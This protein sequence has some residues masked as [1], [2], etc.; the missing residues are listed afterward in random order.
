MTQKPHLP[1]EDVWQ[2][3]CDCLKGED[4]NSIQNQLIR[5]VWFEA[6]Y[7]MVLESRRLTQNHYS[8]KPPINYAFHQFIDQ[9]FIDA[10]L[11]R[12]RKIIGDKQ[13]DSLLGVKGVFSF[14]SLLKDIKSR[15]SE[16]TR[17]KYFQLIKVPYDRELIML[18]KREF[19]RSIAKEQTAFMI[20]R[21]CDVGPTDDAHFTFDG[22]SDR[23]AQNRS[24]AD[25]ASPKFF[26]S[27]ENSLSSADKIIDFVNKSIA[28]AATP[29]SRQEVRFTDIKIP[30]QNLWQINRHFAEIFNKL[31]GFLSC[32]FLMV[33][34]FESANL[35]D[36]WDEPLIPKGYIDHIRD[37][38]NEIRNE[39]EANME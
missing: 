36:Y 23:S 18:K 39:T 25:I 17:I 29:E 9:N 1:L 3:W 11:S 20:P 14:W 33:L 34:P 15:Q 37:Y 24:E 16:I 7:R 35:F 31:S 38:F 19:T 27:I 10:H 26:E 12:V 2:V 8:N 6:I 32:S 22:Y 13:R 30:F 4:H 21:E 5:M 28:H